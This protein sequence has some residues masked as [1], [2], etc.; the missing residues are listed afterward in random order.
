MPST[1]IIIPGSKV[2]ENVSASFIAN[3]VVAEVKN[4]YGSDFPCTLKELDDFFAPK[5]PKLER[6]TSLSF[7]KKKDKFRDLMCD[8]FFDIDGYQAFEGIWHKAFNEALSE[9][10]KA[11]NTLPETMYFS[12]CDSEETLFLLEDM[13]LDLSIGKYCFESSNQLRVD[14]QNHE[15]NDGWRELSRLENNLVCSAFVATNIAI[16]TG[17]SSCGGSSGFGDMHSDIEYI[18]NTYGLNFAGNHSN[19]HSVTSDDQS[20]VIIEAR[21]PSSIEEVKAEFAKRISL[22]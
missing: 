18:E 7:S 22:I 4:K 8:L 3:K 6:H 19:Y 12:R 16:D 2:L 9:V 5:K 17:T 15:Y 1:K 14:S 11:I 13:D 20:I 10:E 21:R